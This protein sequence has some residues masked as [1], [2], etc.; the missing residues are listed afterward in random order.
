MSREKVFALLGDRPKASPENHR[1]IDTQNLDGMTVETL[2]LDLNGLEDVPSYFIKPAMNKSIAEP[3]PV[4]LYHHSHGGDF[5][6]GKDEAIR[7]THYLQPTT[8]AKELTGMGYAVLVI[9]AWA[10]G[11]R[12]GKKESELFKEMLVKGQVMWG[13]MLYDAIN[14]VDYLFTREDVDSN[15]IG[16]IGMSMGGLMSWW[17]AALDERIKVSVD[18]SAQ[19]DLE[20]LIDTRS[21]DK[22]GF[23]SYVPQLLKYFTTSDIQSLIAPRPRL[24][25]VGRND[26]LCPSVGVTKLENSLKMVYKD[27]GAEDKFKTVVT[28]GGHQETAHMRS[29]WKQFIQKHL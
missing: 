18:I 13:M 23:Y 3:L 9:D 21:L 1:L 24:S 16:T 26:L 10:F 25:L 22:H 11:E 2:L 6:L 7:G 14:A 12:G 19:V 29:E 15:R 28:S 27:L 8:F 4:I 20:A 17:L 5:E